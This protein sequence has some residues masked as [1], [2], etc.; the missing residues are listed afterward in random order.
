MELNQQHQQGQLDLRIIGDLIARPYKIGLY[1]FAPKVRVFIEKE[2]Y[3]IKTAENDFELEQALRLRHEVFIFEILGKKKLFGI[4]I[5]RYDMLCDHL[6]VIDKKTEQ[7]VGTYRFNSDRYSDRFYSEMEFNLG[8]LMRKQGVKLE[9]GRACIHKDYRGSNMMGL[10][11]EGLYAYLGV[12]GA[13]YIFGC[14]S[15]QTTDPMDAAR[16]HL[17][18]RGENHADDSMGIHPVKKYAIRNFTRFTQT[19]EME[20]EDALRR[21][22]A[23]LPRLIRD[24]FRF[25]AVICGEPALDMAFRCVDVFTILDMSFLNNSYREE[26]FTK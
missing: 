17:A 2:E 9:I 16:V 22:R 10:L 11:W 19:A 24:Y 8:T 6:L 21:G 12:L 5:D 26:R 13:R 4:D 1:R 14:S 18:I 23:I 15:I 20:G 3:V 7:V 25:G